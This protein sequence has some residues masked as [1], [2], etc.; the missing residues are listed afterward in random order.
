M[1]LKKPMLSS[2]EAMANGSEGSNTS[3]SIPAAR[4]RA[5]PCPDTS[6]LGSAMVETTFLIPAAI[7]ESQHGPVRPW[8]EQGSRVT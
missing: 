4:S 1:R 7:K 5:K 3:T 8:C 2:R 6:G